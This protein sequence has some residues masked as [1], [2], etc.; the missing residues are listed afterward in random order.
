MC[1]YLKWKYV[2]VSEGPTEARGIRSFAAEDTEIGS[3]LRWVLET[4]LSP[5]KMWKKILTI[6]PFAQPTMR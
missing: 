1:V 6:E 3:H 4:D 5:L 2:H